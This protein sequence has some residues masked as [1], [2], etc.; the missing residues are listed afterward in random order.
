MKKDILT[1]NDIKKLVD[2][3][4]EKIRSDRI[5]S[6]YFLQ[7]VAV[8]WD[9]HLPVMYRFWQNVLFYSGNYNGNPMQRHLEIHSKHPF[10]IQDFTQWTLLFNETVDELFE[11]ANAELIK[12]R[13]QNISTIMQIK[14]FK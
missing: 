2:R 8:D 5:L 13:A 7:V 1:G 3:F 11:G 10:N 14:I 12:Q 4:Y 6:P 9:K